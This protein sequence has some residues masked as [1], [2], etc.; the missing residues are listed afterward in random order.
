MRVDWRIGR[1]IF[2]VGV[3]QFF[4]AKPNKKKRKRKE[5]GGQNDT[6]RRQKL[7]LPSFSLLSGFSAHPKNLGEP[8]S[9]EKGIRRLGNGVR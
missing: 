9:P 7:F 1:H 4:Q 8:P 3:L 2:C 6:G 5:N